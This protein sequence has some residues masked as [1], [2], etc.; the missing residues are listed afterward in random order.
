MVVPAGSFTIFASIIVHRSR[1]PWSVIHRSRWGRMIAAYH[2]DA[3]DMHSRRAIPTALIR[4]ATCQSGVLTREQVRGHDLSQAVIDRL[5]G[6]GSWQRLCP[7]LYLTHSIEP[8]WD[9]LAWAGTLLG[10]PRSRLGPEASAYLHGLVPDPPHP[11]DVLVPADKVIQV[12]DAW[13][14]L[15]ERPTARTGR[16]TGAPPRLTRED[17]VLDLAAS[18][19]AAEV[20]GLVTQA[21]QNRLTTPVRLQRHLDRR[22]R[23]P[24]RTLLNRL[25]TDVAEGAE[26][27][28]ELTYLRTVERL[29]GLPRGIRQGSRPELPYLRDV[30]YDRYALL[31]ELDGRRWH[32]GVSAFRDMNR[33]NLHALLDELTMRFGW[34]DVTVRPCSVAF[35]VYLMLSRRGYA[36]PFLRCTACQGVPEI[37]LL[38]A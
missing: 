22:S 26:S 10:G 16:S 8:S 13:R 21:V 34:I 29:H 23:H 15:R 32:D 35:Q 25:L 38:I 12:R 4:L 20:I 33:D 2:P 3:H 24:H 36:E 19:S 28:L 18:R 9:A 1:E 31:V 6:S 14:F 11:V 30:K 37:E 7:G 27:A 17:T 5:I